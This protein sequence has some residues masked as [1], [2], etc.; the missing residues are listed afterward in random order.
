MPQNFTDLFNTALTNLTTTLE[1]VLNLTVINDPRNLCRL[2][3][4]LTRQA[5][6]HLTQT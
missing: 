4:L 5:S 3:L 6:K 2:A 1:G